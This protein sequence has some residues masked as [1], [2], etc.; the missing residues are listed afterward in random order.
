MRYLDW[1]WLA[2]AAIVSQARKTSSQYL[3]HIGMVF[4]SLVFI[5]FLQPSTSYQSN[6]MYFGLCHEPIQRPCP[7]ANACL[8]C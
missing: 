6:P 8:Q 1:M 7:S 2:I 3:V 5:V 4:V